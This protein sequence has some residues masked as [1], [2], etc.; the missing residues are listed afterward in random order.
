[1]KKTAAFSVWLTLRSTRCTVR[2]V[3]PRGLAEWGIKMAKVTVRTRKGRGLEMVWKDPGSNKTRTRKCKT[4]VTREAEREAA[5]LETKINEG[6]E[7][8]PISWS[9][10]V[11]RARKEMYPLKS[12]FYTCTLDR[13]I[14]KWN[15]YAENPGRNVNEIHDYDIS[16][17]RQY[18]TSQVSQE[19]V[20]MYLRHLKALFGWGLKSG[21][22]HHA[23][24]IKIGESK[25]SDAVRK[26]TVHESAFVEI[27]HAC[28]KCRPNDFETWFRFIEGIWLC[29]LRIGEALTLSWDEG[30]LQID[31]TSL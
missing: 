29:G 31:L 14:T 2:V 20:K 16:R 30:P 11:N 10:F 22:I 6:K 15:C 5:I 25:R 18:L 27:T 13:A 4:N 28:R 26:Y 8:Y 19:S 9:A 24:N 1:M 3:K 21:T 7:G 23:P 12:E 17:F